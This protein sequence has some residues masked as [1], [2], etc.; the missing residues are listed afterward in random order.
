MKE[1][2][3]VFLTLIL[4][5][6]CTRNNTLTV[7]GFVEDP[8][9]DN[10]T[11]YFVAL[12]GPITKDVDSTIII[13]G[14]FSFVKK[15]D[16]LCVKILR[17]PVRY[18]DAVEDLVAVLEAGTIDV[19]LSANSNGYGTRLNNRLQEWKDIKHANDSTQ[20]ALYAQK[21]EEG[22]SQAAIDSLLRRSVILNQEYRSYV[23]RLLNENLHNGIGLLLFKVYY[24]DL[25]AEEK[26]RILD[27][28]GNIYRDNDEQ[29][30]IM[31][32]NDDALK[33]L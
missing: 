7:N 30:K 19:T 8:D 21:A 2:F 28:T 10:T 15:A 13:N 3:I 1:L 31:I 11:V 33:A 14:R 18:P 25:P 4:T 26:K 29:L 32:D 6:A 23:R 24:H 12:D 16:S 22:I 5:A 20:G 27:I 17:V 9:L